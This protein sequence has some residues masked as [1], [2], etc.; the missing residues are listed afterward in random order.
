MLSCKK[1]RWRS[2]RAAGDAVA[3]APTKEALEVRRGTATVAVASPVGLEPLRP[4]T[5]D[6][7][8]VCA[9]PPAAVEAAVL[10]DT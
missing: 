3:T 10:D 9:P 5:V 1:A 8:V 2:S 4:E 7:V 6:S